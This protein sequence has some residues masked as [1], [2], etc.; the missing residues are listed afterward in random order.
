MYTII[1]L[2]EK[3]E[4]ALE[5]IAFV[6]EPR[7]LYEPVDYAISQGGKRVRPALVL[8]ACDMFGGDVEKAIYPALGIEIFHNF[9]L[10]HDDIMDD[11]PIRRGN[12]TVY[13]KWN[14]NRAI[15]S[16]DVMMILANEY[17]SKVEQ[18]TLK[19]V[20][21]AFNKAA[22]EVCEG[23]QYDMNYETA[24]H[25]SI[26]DYLKMIRLKTA[27]LLAAS[28]EIGAIIS[29]TDKE[30]IHNIYS[31][32]EN[33]GM[34]FQLQDDLLDVFGKEEKFGKQTGGDI[35]ANKKTYLYL[36]ALE[37]AKDEDI[38]ILNKYFKVKNIPDD[39]KI[40]AVKELYIKWKVKEHAEREI[41][42]YH[43]EALNNLSNISVPEESKKELRQFAEKL[44]VRDY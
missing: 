10:L 25:V 14:A 13:K 30:N 44:L 7:E 15:L 16:G 11:A 12:E 19:N 21:H 39:V 6:R 38:K 26:Q 32:G 35:A 17:I 29:G 8:L 27:V 4:T 41:K 33:I 37:L 3:I 20:L 42:R 34:A 1:Q 5:S 9:T 43:T 18:A 40:K 28:L 24:Q 31:F 36:K 23:Q 22:G 2:Q